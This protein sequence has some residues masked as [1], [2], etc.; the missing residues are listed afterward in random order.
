MLVAGMRAPLFLNGVLLEE[1][2]SVAALAVA[3][4]KATHTTSRQKT[5]RLEKRKRFC[6]MGNPFWFKST[7]FDSTNVI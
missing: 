3:G 6:N 5:M 2:A 1:P 4:R 7:V